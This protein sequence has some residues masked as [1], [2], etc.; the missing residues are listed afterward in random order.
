MS[1]VLSHRPPGTVN[2]AVIV[3]LLVIGI[4]CEHWLLDLVGIHGRGQAW[5]LIPMGVLLGIA[6]T[7]RRRQYADLVED[8][9][10]SLHVVLRGHDFSFPLEH[11]GSVVLTT[12]GASRT[13]VKLHFKKASSFRAAIRFY[14]ALPADRPTIQ[15]DLERLKGRVEGQQRNQVAFDTLERTRR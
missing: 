4:A 6:L 1:V 10:D 5:F 12:L 3:V 15:A 2:A 11:I 9:G 8:R 14:G 7:Y 13:L